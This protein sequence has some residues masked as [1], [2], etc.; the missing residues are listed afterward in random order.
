MERLVFR[1]SAIHGV[2][3]F[4]KADIPK[5]TRVL[6]YVGEKIDKQESLR[7]CETNNPYIFTLD[8]TGDIDGNVSWNP[9]RFVNHSCAPDCEVEVDGG[10]IWV[11]ASRDINAG[12]EITFN[13]G[14]DLEDYQQYP[15]H[16]GAPDCAGYIVAE[17]FFGHVRTQRELRQSSI[18]QS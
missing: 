11:V 15:C 1:P 2:G 3:A 16:C 17:E 6:E 10:R 13:Y 18:E 14:F 12:E 5:G 4:A 8:E 7:R 9:A